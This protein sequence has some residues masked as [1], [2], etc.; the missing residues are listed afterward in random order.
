MSFARKRFVTAEGTVVSLSRAALVGLVVLFGGLGV[1][2]VELP[3]RTQAA[4]YLIGMVGLNLPHG[5]Y[6]HV[7]NLRRRAMRFRGRYIAAYVLLA[8]GFV[9]L[10]LAAPVAGLGL[11][12]VVAALKGGGGD[13]HVLA[14]TTGTSH[15]RR[16]AQRWLAFV[17]RGGAVMAVPMVAW[18]GTFRG[19]AWLMV[20]LVEPGALADAASFETV[21]SLVGVGYAVTVLAHLSGGFLTRTGDGAYVA[22]VAETLLL[23]TYFA[24]VPVVVAVGLY[25]PLWYSARQVARELAVE[26]PAT[27]GSDLLGEGSV[28]LRSW[29]IL[30]AGALATTIVAAGFWLLVPNPLANAGLLYGGVA[31]WSVFISIIALPHVVVGSL[32][33]RTRGIWHVP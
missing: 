17:A 2:G 19:F 15:L 8:G 4:V 33:D 13:L 23:I 21:R 26:E 6:E 28:V 22:D 7:A 25:F 32:L 1:A 14:A 10:F 3:M 5:G 11:A 12:V 18:P 30:V 16:R 27:K 9:G 31:F 29:G 24:V 20:A